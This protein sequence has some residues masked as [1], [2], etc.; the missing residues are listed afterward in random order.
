M[1]RYRLQVLKNGIDC[2]Y[3]WISFENEEEEARFGRSGSVAECIFDF[4]FF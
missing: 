3:D 2:N 1:R 4:V